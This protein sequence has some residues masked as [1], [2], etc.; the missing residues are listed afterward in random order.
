MDAAKKPT[1][2]RKARVLALAL[3][4]AFSIPLSL[5][6]E[7]AEAATNAPW[8]FSLLKGG[9]WKSDTATKSRNGDASA[10]VSPSKTTLFTVSGKLGL[11]VRTSGGAYATGYYTTT[12]CKTLNMAYLSG[13]GTLTQHKLYGQ[14]DSSSAASSGTAGGTWTP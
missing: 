4:L 5:S 8:S 3:V 7:S 10:T 2:V 1:S 13:Y 9:T 6:V 11:R 14:I 12:S